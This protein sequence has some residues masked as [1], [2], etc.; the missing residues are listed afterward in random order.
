[1]YEAGE[2]GLEVG[3]SPE[4]LNPDT[5]TKTGTNQAKRRIMIRT[6]KIN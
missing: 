4:A 2:E 3:S 5:K 1:M 6:P